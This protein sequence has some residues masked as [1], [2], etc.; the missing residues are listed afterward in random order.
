MGTL[1]FRRV[2]GA[3]SAGTRPNCHVFP[4]WLDA[5]EHCGGTLRACRKSICLDPPNTTLADLVM[6]LLVANPF[7]AVRASLWRQ[8]S[9]EFEDGLAHGW[10]SWLGRRPI[11]SFFPPCC[12]ESAMLEKGVDDHC[13]KRMTVK[14]LPGSS[15]EVIETEFFF[16]LL[17]SLLANPS[18]LD[19]SRQGAQVGLRRQIGEIVFFLSRH[20]VF[21]DQPG[22]FPGGRCC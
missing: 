15:L 4:S 11:D 2:D 16:Q 19:G 7:S 13:H 10:Q 12:C 5:L 22:L 17:V 21:T 18:R 20:P 8:S 6:L 9:D 1:R 14:A 3:G